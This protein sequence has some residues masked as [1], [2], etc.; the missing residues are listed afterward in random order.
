[1]TVPSGFWND[2]VIVLFFTVDDAIQPLGTFWKL[3]LLAHYCARFS[4]I[5]LIF[6]VC[7]NGPV[8]KFLVHNICKYIHAS[9]NRKSDAL[10]KSLHI[11]ATFRS[12]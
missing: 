11:T 9:T 10:A 1:M 12:R 7:D 5:L 3:H 6:I 4:T 8:K 2:P